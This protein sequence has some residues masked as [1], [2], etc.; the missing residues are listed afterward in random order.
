MVG[1]VCRV[2]PVRHP[3]P[4]PNPSPNPVRHPN[5]NPNPSPNPGGLCGVVESRDRALGRD[6]VLVRF[7]MDVGAAPARGG[8]V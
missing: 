7:L 1:T 3:T 4:T 2:H 6:F 8:A 5:P